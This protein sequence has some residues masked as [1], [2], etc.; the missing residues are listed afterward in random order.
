[1]THLAVQSVGTALAVESIHA[2]AVYRKK[3]GHMCHLHHVITYAGAERRS[4]QEHERNARSY[5]EK[6]GHDPAGLE[7]LHVPDFRPFARK[8]RVD[9]KRKVLVE[10]ETAFKIKKKKITVRDA[11]EEPLGR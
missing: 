3:D 11:G 2:V 6:M 1:M 4:Q 8:Y 7:V 5:A 9:L 10:D